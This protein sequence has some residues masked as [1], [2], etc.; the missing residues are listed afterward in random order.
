MNPEENYKILRSEYTVFVLREGE[1]GS[2]FVA[3]PKETADAD[4][5]RIVKSTPPGDWRKVE[6]I[7][8]DAIQSNAVPGSENGANR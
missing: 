3:L 8:F 2:E 6:T 4:M 7:N 5:A 1:S